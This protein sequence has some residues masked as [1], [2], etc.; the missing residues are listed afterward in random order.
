MRINEADAETIARTLDGIGITREEAIVNFR[1]IY[2][3][4]TSVK[5]LQLVKDVGEVTL[6]NNESR[7]LFDYVLTDHKGALQRLSSIGLII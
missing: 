3:D 2:G 7:I 1:E 4:F 6:R 5:D